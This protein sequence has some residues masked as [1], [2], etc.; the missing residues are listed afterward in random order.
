MSKAIEGL[1]ARLM[2]G[3]QME[4]L[5]NT[6]VGEPKGAILTITEQGKRV[7]SSTLTET[8][9]GVAHGRS[10]VWN[11]AP[12]SAWSTPT[13]SAT[14]SSATVTASPGGFSP[15]HPPG[16][17]T[18]ARCRLAGADQ[19]AALT[20]AHR[21]SPAPPPIPGLRHSRV[22]PDTAHR[23]ATHARG[24]VP[25]LCGPHPAPDPAGPAAL[26]HQRPH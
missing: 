5:E 2:P 16:K 15:P 4:C 9:G 17:G 25:P 10:P 23:H 12:D 11:C 14:R 24:P 21:L 19:L 7:F 22:G 13:R 6:N 26:A 3:T 1:A 8:R 20:G 18:A